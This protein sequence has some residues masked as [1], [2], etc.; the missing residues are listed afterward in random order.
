[1]TLPACDTIVVYPDGSAT[2]HGTVQHVESLPDGCSVLILDRTAAH[3]ID[4][5]WPDQP[6]DR[7]TLRIGETVIELT[8]VVVGGIY[9]GRLF[10]GVDV[11]VRT[12]AQGWTFVVAHLIRDGPP[13]EGSP[14]TVEVDSDLRNA[15]SLGHTA[16][17]LAALALDSV[18]KDVWTKV[19]PLDD[20]G[21]PAFDSLAIKSSHIA[22]YRSEDVY[23]LGKSLRRKGFP[24]SGFDDP[25]GIAA[26]VNRKLSS[27]IDAGG[28]I[29]IEKNG[30]GLSDR[31]FWVCDLGEGRAS[32]PC[33]GTHVRNLDAIGQILVRFEDSTVEGTK[34]ITMHTSAIARASE[35]CSIYSAS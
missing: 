25:N 22:P 10:L 3:P 34:E 33:G 14:V 21:N 19:A 26:E 24:S 17:H 35:Q 13:I 4:A 15:L 18:L 31:R 30:N 11:P 5:N 8:D 9:D 20:L 16:C 28:T 23:R 32:I 1:M 7:G 29:R 6:A 27:W 2:S 12:R